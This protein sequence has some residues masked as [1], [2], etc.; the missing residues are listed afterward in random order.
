MTS[1][2]FLYDNLSV[3][4]GTIVDDPEMPLDFM[5]EDIMKDELK[6]QTLLE[7]LSSLI[8]IFSRRYPNTN[9]LEKLLS[10]QVSVL[11]NNKRT[12]RDLYRKDIKSIYCEIWKEKYI[13]KIV[14]E[15]DSTIIDMAELRN[16]LQTLNF[17]IN[18]FDTVAMEAIASVNSSIDKITTKNSK[19]IKSIEILMKNEL[20][21]AGYDEN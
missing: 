21:N 10:K 6:N 17:S 1:Y 16:I 7:F 19:L 18:L 20:Q 11:E 8:E 4:A 5:M 14:I 15:L 3:Q 2:N 12:F 13:K 9:K